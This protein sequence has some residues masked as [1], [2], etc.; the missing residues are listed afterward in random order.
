MKKMKARVTQPEEHKLNLAGE[1]VRPPALSTPDDAM[2][3]TVERIWNKSSTR[4]AQFIRARVAD[5]ATAEDILH[6]VFVKFQNR[7]DELRDPAKVQGWLFLVARNAVIDHYRTRKQTSELTESLPAGAGLPPDAMEMEELHAAFGRIIHSLPGPSRE[8]IV[9]TEFEGLTQ[10][11]LARRLGISLSAAKSRVQR[12]REQLKDLLLD[13]CEREF[14]HA[15]GS[16]PCPCGLLPLV[17]AAKPV[18][19]RKPAPRSNKSKAAR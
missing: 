6:D 16:Q 18:L 17:T 5:P 2:K 14:S 10:E 3:T 1:K 7:V 19:K 15:V 11:E 13:F 4:L 9:L 8:A 12:A